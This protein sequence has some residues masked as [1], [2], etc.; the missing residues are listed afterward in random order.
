MN[1]T[2]VL[3]RTSSACDVGACFDRIG[4]ELEQVR[5]ADRTMASDEQRLAWIERA[6]GLQRQVDALAVILVG[7]ADEANSAMRARHSHLQ[8]WLARSGQETTRQA[9]ATVWTARELERRPQVREAAATGQISLGQAK[10]INT[11]LDGL[12]AGLDRAQR[13]QAE[14]LMLAAADHA[15]PDVLR[16][17]SEK[18]LVRVAPQQTETP[19][20]RA[21][22]L[23]QRDVRA[24]SR[25]CLRFG[26]ECD[27]SLDFSGN[28]PIV[29]A[30]R[31][32]HLVQTVADRSYRAAKDTHNRQ[33]LLLTPQ[34]RLADALVVVVTA[35]ERRE[36]GRHRAGAFEGSA[37][38]GVVTAG[39]SA[40]R[41]GTAIGGSVGR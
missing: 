31:L 3:E 29:D 20:A 10:A 1:A 6:R 27:G 8:D 11:A 39:G 16:G 17:M 41:G 28:L 15:A 37:G 13:V 12:P 18:V 33:G 30:R 38:R 7:E 32:Q 4:C 21:E 2:P 5:R 40:G 35:A 19:E 24:A 14:S 36:D 26:A 34:Q 23:T 9:S 25:R 22:R